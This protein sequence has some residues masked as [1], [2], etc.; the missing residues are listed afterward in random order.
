MLGC[1]WWRKCSGE[2]GVAKWWG[3][4]VTAACTDDRGPGAGLDWMPTMTWFAFSQFSLRLIALPRWQHLMQYR[5]YG[6]PGTPERRLVSPTQSQWDTYTVLETGQS[7]R[8][9]Q[10]H[11]P[12]M[13]EQASRTASQY[14]PWMAG[15][16]SACKEANTYTCMAQLFSQL[17][18]L[19]DELFTYFSQNSRVAHVNIAHRHRHVGIKPI[20]GF[21]L[22]QILQ[23]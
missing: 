23:E 1:L 7:T 3:E 6:A 15:N 10:M 18:K 4:R 12:D 19:P 20:F 22:N 17:H 2:V 13:C 14:T 5:S 21:L 11:W 9:I 8:T 16:G